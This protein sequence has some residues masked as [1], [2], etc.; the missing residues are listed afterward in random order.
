M[1]RSHRIAERREVVE[2]TGGIGLAHNRVPVW[3]MFVIVG[4]IG[5]GLFYLITYSVTSTGGFNGPGT[6]ALFL[7]F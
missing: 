4:I 1:A 2:Y 5:W 3:L 6:G 7:R